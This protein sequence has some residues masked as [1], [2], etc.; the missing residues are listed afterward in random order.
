MVK[1][2]VECHRDL[3]AR[4]IEKVRQAHPD[5]RADTLDGLRI[6]WDDSWVHVRPSNTEPAVRVIAE[7]KAKKKAQAIAKGIVEMAEDM[8]KGQ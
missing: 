6:D 3:A 5:G 8:I 7:A 4:L 1:F 2:K